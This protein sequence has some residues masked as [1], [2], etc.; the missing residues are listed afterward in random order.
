[1]A[2]PLPTQARLKKEPQ[3]LLLEKELGYSFA[4]AFLTRAVTHV[5]Y[6][7][8]K[9]AGHNEVLEFLGDAV[10]DLAI[11]DLLIRSF[12]REKRG[13]PVKNARCAGEFRSAR[14]EGGCA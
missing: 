2:S 13:R 11:S 14:G 10:L 4:D 6:N 7:R 12:P 5:S 1:M 9:S 3:L 8:E